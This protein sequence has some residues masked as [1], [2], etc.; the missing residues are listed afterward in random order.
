MA[1]AAGATS[2][3]AA[4]GH[5]HGRPGRPRGRGILALTLAGALAAALCYLRDPPWLLETTSGIGRWE[6]AADGTRFRWIG[7]HA[8]LFI[9]SDVR[10]VEI[11][12]RTTFDAPGDPPVTVAISLDDRPV[13]RVVLSDASWRRA[14]VRLPPRG[15]RRV[16][17]IDIRADRLRDD[18]RGAM[19]GSL[20]TD[21]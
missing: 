12:L 1:L 14:V 20:I 11:P 2:S 9:P 6:T 16:R 21:H 18:N 7:G 19:I 3:E 13:D 5:S 4:A 17:R 10:T 15:G 8:S